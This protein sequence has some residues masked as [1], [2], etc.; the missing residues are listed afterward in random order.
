LPFIGKC[1]TTWATAQAF[2]FKDEASLHAC[3]KFT[4]PANEMATLE[5]AIWIPGCSVT[6]K[7]SNVCW[8]TS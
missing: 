7:S 3:L 2:H 5:G 8:L 6:P 1:T 4:E